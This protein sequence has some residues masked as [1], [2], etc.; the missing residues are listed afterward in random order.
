MISTLLLSAVALVAP[1][2]AN[3]GGEWIADWDAAAKLAKESGKDL[4]VDFTGSDW[5]GWCVKLHDEVFQHDEFLK[6]VGDKYV[7]VALD[8][9]RDDAV[10]AKVPNPTRNAALQKRYHV[11]GFP[12]ILLMAADGDVIGQTG[13]QQGGP[14]AYLTH[15]EE[16]RTAGLPLLEEQDKMEQKIVAAKDAEKAALIEEA[17]TRLA[18]LTEENA[19]LATKFGDLVRLGLVADPD[20]K[21]GLKRKSIEA[22]LKAGQLD[23]ELATVVRTLDPKNE[24]GL[25]ERVVAAEM[26]SIGSEEEIAPFVKKI[27]ELVAFGPL[28][29]S[30]IKLEICVNAAFFNHRFLKNPEAAK[31]YATMVKEG[32][33]ELNPQVKQL[34]DSI[35]A[36]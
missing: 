12:T 16:L 30:K 36:G 24:A 4:L 11:R 32:G 25:L 6:G 7:L 3:R 19:F 2:A 15:L 20:N 10:K 14:A 33:E 17:M 5:C 18:A 23:D 13:Y 34:I 22:L 8:F 1:P 26:G 31:K 35:L 29:D 21:S 9:P 27:D 28:K